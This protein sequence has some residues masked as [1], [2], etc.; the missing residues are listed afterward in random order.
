MSMV[1]GREDML[2]MRMRMGIMVCLG[3]LVGMF[4][5]SLFWFL[6]AGIC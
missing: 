6:L 5:C 3:G 4:F 1:D 2:L